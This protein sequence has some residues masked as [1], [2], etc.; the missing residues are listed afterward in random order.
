VG[1][2]IVSNNDLGNSVVLD[3]FGL[4]GRW[5][6]K[7]CLGSSNGDLLIGQESD[8]GYTGGECDARG[9]LELESG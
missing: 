2:C 3:G 8:G 1:L 9:L 7:G 4:G 6:Y 5:I